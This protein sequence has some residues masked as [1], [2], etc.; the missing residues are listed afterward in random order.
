MKMPDRAKACHLGWLMQACLKQTMPGVNF[1]FFKTE[2][3]LANLMK[4]VA[5]GKPSQLAM[6][7]NMKDQA[8]Y[9]RICQENG[10]VRRG[11]FSRREVRRG[12]FGVV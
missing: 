10:L 1:G 11:T 2:P 7:A 4:D 5:A 12:R 6:E 3:G 9:A 8:R